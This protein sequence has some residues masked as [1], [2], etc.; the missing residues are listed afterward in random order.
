MV[1]AGGAAAALPAS[2]ISHELPK[3]ECGGLSRRA[4][5]WEPRQVSLVRKIR[6]LPI[7]EKEF[8]PPSCE[9]SEPND[10]TPTSR[11]KIQA[12]GRRTNSQPYSK[13]S[14]QSNTHHVRSLSS[15]SAS[16]RTPRE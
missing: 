15:G 4:F 12:M 1:A 2:L 7:N 13:V 11:M 6:E 8:G 5:E 3:T 16:R 14:V 9:F 10:H